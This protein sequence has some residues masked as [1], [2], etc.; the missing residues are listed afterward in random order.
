VKLEIH[1]VLINT[2]IPL[3]SSLESIV[4]NLDPKKASFEPEQFPV[5]IYKDWGVSFLLFSSGSCIIT[6]LK[7]VEDANGA[8]QQFKETIEGVLEGFRSPFSSSSPVSLS[9]WSGFV[10]SRWHRAGTSRGCAR[11]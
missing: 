8:I 10:S 4:V 11:G 1:N 9:V 3:K 5:L 2:S 7:K 6:G